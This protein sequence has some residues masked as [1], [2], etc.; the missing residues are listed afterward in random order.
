MSSL[1]LDWNRF[2]PFS[3]VIFLKKRTLRQ[4][5]IAM[6]KS[7]RNGCFFLKINKKG[8]FAIAV[9][10]R[11]SDGINVTSDRP[12]KTATGETCFCQKNLPQLQTRI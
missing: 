3:S 10:D 7:P 6:Q 5:N 8:W 2:G 12:Q 1:N 11:L 9:F 4:S